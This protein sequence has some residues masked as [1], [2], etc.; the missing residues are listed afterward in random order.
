LWHGANWTFVVWGA[1]HGAYLM[2][3]H[4]WRYLVAGASWPRRFPR[5]YSAA[6]WALTLL[7][8]VV[9]WVFFRSESV[10]HA[11]AMLRAMASLHGFGV[12]VGGPAELTLLATA[13]L[14]AL[15]VPNTN[16]V[17]HY[18]FGWEGEGD[19][20]AGKLRWRPSGAWA[21]LTVGLFVL[22]AF[23]GVTSR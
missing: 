16:Q 14:W 13:A 15:A 9:G 10:T 7:A 5:A 18:F 2:V 6:A 19:R 4:F 1:L 23:A 17:M 3:N 22:S 8:V 11:A 21:A 12:N 20:E